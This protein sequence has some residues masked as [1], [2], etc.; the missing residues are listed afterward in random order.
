MNTNMVHFRRL[1]KNRKEQKLYEVKPIGS[2][3]RFKR[4]EMCMT[5]EE[6]CEGICSVSY[7]SKLENNQIEVGHQFIPSLVERFKLDEVY[8][9]I[10]DFY[11]EDVKIIID[12]LTYGTLP[13][14]DMTHKYLERRD[15]QSQLVRMG[16]FMLLKKYT[17]AEKS[18]RDLKSYIP[19]LRDNDF[20]LF[21][22]LS[23][24]QLF[25]LNRF[26][27]AFELLSFSPKYEDLSQNI[28]LLLLKWRLLNAFRMHRISEVINNY[29]VYVNMLVDLEH[30]DLLK[31]IRN[32][33]VQFEAYFQNP[34]NLEETLSKMNSLSQSDRDFVI[35]KSMFFNQKYKE[36]I[37]LSKPYYRNSSQWLVIYLMSLDYEKEHEKLALILA[38]PQELRDL[39]NT[40][41]LLMT[42]LRHKY[43]GDKIQLLN[44]LRRE[45]LGIKHLTDEYHVLDY[46]MVDAQKLFSNHQH[47]KD[48]V[49]I[50]T[51]YLPILKYL[52]QSDKN[53]QSDE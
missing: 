51:H 13:Y 43:K 40:S 42:H 30:F 35:A 1:V 6:G 12:H 32:E 47:Y 52:K 39:C 5:L 46:L 41:R 28:I 45:I 2:A 23:N 16:Y 31:E 10:E 37:S 14:E 38:A 9:M 34:K 17:E 26:S 24:M 33:Y 25:Q 4:K 44:Y 21:L 22:I 20:A 49:Q 53:D 19:H 7:L 50:T 8:D 48:A 29:S 27:E 15:Y 3:I 18:F 36:V 11:E